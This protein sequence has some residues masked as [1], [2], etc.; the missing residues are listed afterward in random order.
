MAVVLNKLQKKAESEIKLFLTNDVLNFMLLTG[1]AGSG[2]TFIT[3]KCLPINGVF[4]AA[5]TNKASKVLKTNVIKHINGAGCKFATIHKMLMLEPQIKDTYVPSVILDA[6]SKPKKVEGDVKIS[7]SDLEAEPSLEE[8]VEV[9][10][11][12]DDPDSD[13]EYV[14]KLCFLYDYK[15]TEY[16]KEYPVW[17]FDECSTISTELW[18]YICS[19]F[20]YMKLCGVNIKMLFLGDVYQL[21]PVGEKSTCVFDIADSEWPVAKLSKIMRAEND[22]M[23]EV[24]K[25][26]YRFMQDMKYGLDDYPENLIGEHYD[27]LLINS[28]QLIDKYIADECKDRIILTYTNSNMRDI[29][30]KIQNILDGKIYESEKQ[31]WFNVGDRCILDNVVSTSLHEKNGEVY[32]F[33]KILK[34]LI[35]SGD[36]YLV[37]KVEMCLVKTNI[38]GLLPSIGNFTAQRLEITNVSDPSETH[39]VFWLD[40]EAVKKAKYALRRSVKYRNVYSLLI[41]SFNDVY[42]NMERGYCMTVYKAQGSQ[43]DSVYVNLNSFYYVFKDK[44]AEYMNLYK[45]T[46]TACSRAKTKLGVSFYIKK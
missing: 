37:D 40:V 1:P 27:S 9:K 22:M 42:P 29:N 46:Y 38:S 15:K 31:R 14:E 16:L 34:D 25:N 33:K 43:Y 18:A 8:G 32:S 2:K 4:Y 19:T 28:K 35:Y 21:P 13:G 11:D 41:K 30:N 20:R 3:S 26:M 39:V 17:V 24:N 5:F 10:R 7:L 44:V 12:N 45:A 36:V 6:G 23:L